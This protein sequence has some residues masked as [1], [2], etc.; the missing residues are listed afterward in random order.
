M[1]ERRDHTPR[2]TA[3]QLRDRFAAGEDLVVLDTRPLEEFN[4]IALPEGIAAPGA[5]LLFR[6]FDAAPDPA[7]PIVVN[8]AGRTRA[9]IGAQALI[10]AGVPN[11]VVSLENGTAAWL[12]AE[13]TPARGA[14]PQPGQQLN[15]CSSFG[16]GMIESGG[17]AGAYVRRFTARRSGQRSQAVETP[18]SVV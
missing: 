16:A 14:T 10:N 1:V 2:I 11:P 15:S 12:L 7:T 17:D 18:T 4:H 5:E 6:V 3:S 9:I 8:C 13:L